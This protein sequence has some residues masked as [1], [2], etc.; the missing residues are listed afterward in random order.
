MGKGKPKG[1]GTRLETGRA[2]SLEGST[3]SPSAS[4]LRDWSNGTT[5]GFQP[6][7]RG[8]TPRSRTERQP[9]AVHLRPAGWFCVF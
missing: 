5:P 1:D 6:G 9:D 3:P 7:D 8:S 2:M 4:T